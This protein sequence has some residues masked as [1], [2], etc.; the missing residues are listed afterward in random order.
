MEEFFHKHIIKFTIIVTLPLWVAWAMADDIVGY[1]QH[2]VAIT[3]EDVQV[4]T[5]NVRHIKGWSWNSKQDHLVLRMN[6]GRR[7]II[8]FYSRC[9]DINF[10]NQLLFNSFGSMSF[11]SI[12]DT[13]TPVTFGRKSMMPCRIK[14]L[15]EMVPA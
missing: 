9:W 2:G 10:A 11:I 14:K 8:E 4:K 6:G 1:S 7:V 12:G 5:I 3:K 15:Y 13:V